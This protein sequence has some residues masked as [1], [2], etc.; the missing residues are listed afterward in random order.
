MATYKRAT[1]V[2]KDLDVT[3]E[4]PPDIAG[5]LREIGSR[6]LRNATR[7]ALGKAASVI[8][9]AARAQPKFP[10]YS[11]ILKQ[12]LGVKKSK[13]TS[14]GIYAL[15]GA[16][17]SFV[18]PTLPLE[19]IREGKKAAKAAG[20]PYDVKTKRMSKPSRYLHLIEKGFRDNKSG[21]FIRGHN[22]LKN[23]GMSTKPQ[24][25]QAIREALAKSLTR[26]TTP[27][28]ITTT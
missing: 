19:T 20:V 22:I 5:S 16:R 25:A 26:A 17:R 12:S 2:P 9:K 13:H 7:N 1:P 15:V 3:V 11:G 21:A 18:G 8:N 10:V 23:A 27:S 4:I 24:V 6:T 28:E 14:R